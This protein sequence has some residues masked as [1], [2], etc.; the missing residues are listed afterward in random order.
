MSQG[1]EFFFKSLWEGSWEAPWPPTPG[2]R[3]YPASLAQAAGITLW[4]SLSLGSHSQVP[5]SPKLYTERSPFHQDIV[6]YWEL[7]PQDECYD[8]QSLRTPNPAWTQSLELRAP[9]V[10]GVKEQEPLSIPWRQL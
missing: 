9:L 4:K 8:I 5:S 3:P 7:S 2:F 10:L 1:S 6:L